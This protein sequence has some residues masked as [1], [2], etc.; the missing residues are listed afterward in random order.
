MIYFHCDNCIHG[1][2][3]P[4]TVDPRYFR[5]LLTIGSTGSYK[6]RKALEDVLVHGTSRKDACSKYGVAQSN[7]SVKYQRLQFVSMT[8]A[9]MCLYISKNS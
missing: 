8:V 9:Q 4:G 3:E 6:M 1:E 2:M 7:F 5:L